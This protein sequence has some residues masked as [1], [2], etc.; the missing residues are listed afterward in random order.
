M[1][2]TQYVETVSYLPYK[3]TAVEKKYRDTRTVSLYFFYPANQV[4]INKSAR[5]FPFAFVA[6]IDAR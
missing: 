4:Y 6:G 2:G 3:Q 5:G 1:L